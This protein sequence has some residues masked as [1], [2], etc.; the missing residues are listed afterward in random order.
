M[1]YH[2]EALAPVL[3]NFYDVGNYQDAMSKVSEIRE[4]VDAFFE[5]VMVND[6]DEQ[7]RANRLAIL[8]QLQNMLA[9][10]ADISVL[11]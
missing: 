3:K 11:Y 10:T 6:K 2:I 1:A 4:D 8:R 9:N 5:H 7:V